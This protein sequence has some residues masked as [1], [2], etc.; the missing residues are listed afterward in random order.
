MIGPLTLVQRSFD[1]LDDAT[2]DATDTRGVYADTRSSDGVYAITN[3]QS[4][5]STYAASDGAEGDQ[6]A[7]EP[8]PVTV[9]N[10]PDPETCVDCSP[11]TPAD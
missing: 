2:A 9:E 7:P 10:C 11:K 1:A 4:T 3:T 8:E 5:D 6:S